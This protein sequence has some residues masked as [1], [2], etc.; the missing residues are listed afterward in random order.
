M[1]QAAP[2]V[3]G[4]RPLIET[5]TRP[6]VRC[7]NCDTLLA[8]EYCHACGQKKIDEDWQSVPRFLRQFIDELINL[9]FKS[10]RSVGALLR[11]GYLPAE[12]LAGRRQRFLGPSPSTRARVDAI[13][14]HFRFD[15]DP[16]AP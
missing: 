9:D 2:D 6:D 16:L 15:I 1:T 8:G 3:P 5:H 12:F 10:V 14:S 13:P 4:R 11:P 7:E